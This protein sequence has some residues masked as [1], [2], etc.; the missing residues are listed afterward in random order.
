MALR[1]PSGVDPSGTT[2]SKRADM[3]YGDDNAAAHL[4]PSA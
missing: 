1:K 4:G 2:D 3:M